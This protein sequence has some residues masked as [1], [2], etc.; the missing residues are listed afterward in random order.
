MNQ[1][2]EVLFLNSGPSHQ[3][4]LHEV[5]HGL[6]RAQKS[7]PPKYLYDQRGSEI[8]EQI[9]RLKEYYPTRAEKEILKTY[10]NE[11]AGLLGD[12]AL[13]IEPGSGS[14][15]KIR[16]LIPHLLR[17]QGY[18][19]VEISSEI[20]WRMTQELN[21]E[22]PDLSVGPI[23]ADF[24]Q[25]MD[26]PLITDSGLGKKVIFFPG[27]TIGNFTPCEAKDLL[28]KFRDVMQGEG[29]LLIGVDMKKDP[30]ILKLAYDD[31]QGVTAN[32][33]LNLLERLN[34]EISANFVPDNFYHEAL[35]NPAEGRVEMHLRSKISQLVRV[36][37]SVFR[38]QQGE[39]IH[40]EN[41]YK[42]SLEEFCE[43]AA[44]VGFCIKKC[45]KDSNELFCMYYFEKV[46]R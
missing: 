19:P 28:A 46:Q 9:C 30:A 45:W 37:Q 6:S 12:D 20:L 8:F 13:I 27:S 23:C 22:F 14:G 25:S 35:Y 5:L 32:F 7:I 15:E 29:G 26:F 41:S 1:D 39:S 38:F 36:N 34:R 16:Y 18:V 24:T 33:N 2:T 21:E 31:P 17:P 44:Q 40:T 42:Y 4:V 3:Q 10:A 43:L 11:M